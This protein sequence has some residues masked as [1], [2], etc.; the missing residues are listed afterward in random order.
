MALIEE[1]LREGHWVF[2]ANCHLMTSWLPALEKLVEGLPAREPAP[3]FRLWLSSAPAAAFPLGLL[4][5]GVK[6][7]TEPP[8][9]LRANLQRYARGG[10]L[11]A[12]CGQAAQAFA[13]CMTH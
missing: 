13:V 11:A 6:M 9:G 12:V 1:G 4:Q 3:G 7:T 10:V 5:R 2:L 8:Q